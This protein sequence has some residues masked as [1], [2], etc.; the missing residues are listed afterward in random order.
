MTRIQ[1]GAIA[2]GAAAIPVF[3]VSTYLGIEE[4]LM[5]KVGPSPWARLALGAL[6]VGIASASVWVAS[7]IRNA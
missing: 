6:V 4:G 3:A 2:I 1:R 5:E 7:Q